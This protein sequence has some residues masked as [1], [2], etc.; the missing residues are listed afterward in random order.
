MIVFDNID[1]VLSVEFDVLLHLCYVYMIAL[2]LSE[3]RA[4]RLH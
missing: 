1:I 4:L 2:S 3:T